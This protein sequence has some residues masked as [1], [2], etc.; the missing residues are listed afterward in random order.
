MGESV[1]AG[2]NLTKRLS[3]VLG[4]FCFGG[5][6]HV[7]VLAMCADIG[8]G[9]YTIGVLVPYNFRLS[10][11]HSDPIKG[12]CHVQQKEI[13]RIFLSTSAAVSAAEDS[14]PKPR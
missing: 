10:V 9:D 1:V 3:L 6:E 13:R 4:R 14:L 12:G 8:N 7:A 11:V 5:G 2:I